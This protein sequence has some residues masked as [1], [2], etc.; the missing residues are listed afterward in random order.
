MKTFI[1]YASMAAL[2][3]PEPRL[4][5]RLAWTSTFRFGHRTLHIFDHE[6]SGGKLMPE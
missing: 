6:R 1:L 2:N 4:Q 5:T 3:L